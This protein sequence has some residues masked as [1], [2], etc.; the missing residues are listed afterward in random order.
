M[1][2]RF[3]AYK[4]LTFDYSMGYADLDDYKYIGEFKHLR[5]RL[6]SVNHDYGSLIRM[7]IVAVPR[8]L[9]SREVKA[10]LYNEF[11]FG[12]KCEHD[13]CNH[14]L[15]YV[16]GITRLKNREWLVRHYI[17]RNV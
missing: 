3:A 8:G 1:P 2:T 5:T 11:E 6:V 4:R 14:E 17:G 15:G 7:H 16:I 12:C 9:D 13:G 10:A